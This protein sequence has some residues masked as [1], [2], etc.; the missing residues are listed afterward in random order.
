MKVAIVG[1]GNISRLHFSAVNENPYT[2][3]VA[4]VDIKPERA[5]RY[6][7]KYGISAYTSYEEMLEK[8]K[9]DAVH[10]CIPHYLHTQYA[11]TALS[12][13]IHVLSEKPCSVSEAE[14]EALRRAQ[15][16]SS[17]SYGV[18]FQNRYNKC[19][20]KIK[21]LSNSGELGKILAVRAFLT[22]DRR[23]GYYSDDWHGR[24]DKECGCLLINQAIHT[25]DL[26]QYIAGG[27]KALT[28]H[29]SNDHLEGVIDGEDTA[30][31]LF[32]L[33]NGVS[34]V[35]YGTTAYAANAPVLIEVA[36]EKGVLRA[37]GEKLFK[38]LPDGGIEEQAIEQLNAPGQHYWGSGHSA[39][40]GDFYECIKQGRPFPVDAFEGGEAALMVAAAYRSA[41]SGKRINIWRKP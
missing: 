15:E 17:A 32:E 34:G 26:I 8:E 36:F 7:E 11:I 29:V 37:E 10:L 9:P 22:W 27:C 20:K 2:R 24:R 31:I 12:R 13:N 1:C 18:C 14:V 5:Q 30:S 4:A 19:I 38:I 3:P 28:A 6:A 16:Q 35:F 23:E 33:A 41:E 21:K 25:L 40:I 39:L